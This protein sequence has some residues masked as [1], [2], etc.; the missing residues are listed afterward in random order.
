MPSF[1][2]MKRTDPSVEDIVW[3]VPCLRRP[4][5]GSAVSFAPRVVR[6]DE[7]EPIEHVPHGQTTEIV[8][9]RSGIEMWKAHAVQAVRSALEAG[10][11]GCLSRQLFEYRRDSAR[12]HRD[13]EMKLTHRNVEGWLLCVSQT[14]EHDDDDYSA[15]AS[16]VDLSRRA[17]AA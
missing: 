17:T 4:Y 11:R 5:D 9:R 3:I 8:T 15:H 10:Q 14:A 6:R 12:P 1:S 2:K 7:H 13:R 16:H